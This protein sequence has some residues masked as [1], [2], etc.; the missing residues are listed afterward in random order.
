MAINIFIPQSIYLES[1]YDRLLAA[2][3]LRIDDTVYIFMMSE[4]PDIKLDPEAI[5]IKGGGL[6]LK[7]RIHLS[8][9]QDEARNRN[10]VHVVAFDL[11]PEATNK[12]MNMYYG[13]TYLGRISLRKTIYGPKS[14]LTAA[15]LFKNDYE[16]LRAWVEYHYLLGF[17]SFVL[18]YNG[19]L[20]DV[21]EKLSECT[22][23][24]GKNLLFIQWPYSYWLDGLPEDSLISHHAQ[25]LMLSHALVFLKDTTDYLC[26][27]D[28]DEYFV[29]PGHKNILDFIHDDP[30]D[31]YIF[32]SRWAK[33]A[34][35]GPTLADG[36]NFFKTKKVSVDHQWVDFP[37]RCKYIA[38]P[39]IVVST[40]M[41]YPFRVTSGAQ[42][43]W[44]EN[45]RGGIYHFHSFTNNP[46]RGTFCP[47]S[48]EWIQSDTLLNIINSFSVLP[49]MHKR[50]TP[51]EARNYTEACVKLSQ[52]I[53]S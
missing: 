2:D 12:S 52:R 41:H 40:N 20:N 4:Y 13:D 42:I 11:P 48:N 30:H 28:L 49:F 23:L 8:S 5:R 46:M 22:F 33:T 24:A 16:N 18:Y 26:F 53:G 44:V 47:P 29:I 35:N 39:E 27:F 45:S 17:D 34:G 38:K 6:N 31:C 50:M 43:L 37:Y 9:H 25:V 7:G 32:Q 36:M 21:L 14:Q 19:C 15:T 1:E 51:S 3:V 10:G